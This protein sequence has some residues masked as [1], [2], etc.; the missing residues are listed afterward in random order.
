MRVG[1]GLCSKSFRG[2]G[3][4]VKKESGVCGGGEATP[5][6]PTPHPFPMRGEL[7][8]KPSEWGS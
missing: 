5:T 7:L 8:R 6:N 2:S 3:A 4:P 1:E